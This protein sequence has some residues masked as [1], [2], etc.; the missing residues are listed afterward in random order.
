M[1]AGFCNYQVE[2]LHIY[3]LTTGVFFSFN[4]TV[5][6]M[7]AEYATSSSSYAFFSSCG[8]FLL[9]FFGSAAIGIVFA[10]ASALISFNVQY[11]LVIC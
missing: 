11:Y 7:E 2:A 10:L 4:S 3:K 1:Y 8:T 5:L 9:M 6:A